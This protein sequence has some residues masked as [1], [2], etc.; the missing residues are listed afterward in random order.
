MSLLS[1]WLKEWVNKVAL[2]LLSRSLLPGCLS[3][4]KLALVC[5]R[6][7]AFTRSRVRRNSRAGLASYRSAARSPP[8]SLCSLL[9]FP[10]QPSSSLSLQFVCLS[11][12]PIRET[13][14]GPRGAGLRDIPPAHE[15]WTPVFKIT[16]VSKPSV[17]GSQPNQP[18]SSQFTYKDTRKGTPQAILDNKIGRQQPN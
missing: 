15:N 3:S 17:Y 1:C 11:P 2:T 5:R 18:C 10:R 9:E 4:R 13:A 8:L 6:P 16:S 12:F 14:P 7:H